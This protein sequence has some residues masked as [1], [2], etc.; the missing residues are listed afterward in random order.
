MS[1][2][3]LLWLCAS[4][5]SATDS[6]LLPRSQQ[7]AAKRY[8]AVPLDARHRSVCAAIALYL[9]NHDYPSQGTCTRSHEDDPNSVNVRRW[10]APW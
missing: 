2:L 1:N 10:T 5:A 3:L 6:V 7:D 9:D 4:L 8:P